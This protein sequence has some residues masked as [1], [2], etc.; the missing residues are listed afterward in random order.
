MLTVQ[1]TTLNRECLLDRPDVLAVVDFDAN[2]GERPT[3]ARHIVTPLA[4]DTPY[5]EVWTSPSGPVT[6]GTSG[7]IHYARTDSET[8]GSLILE[9][10]GEDIETLAHRA[11]AELLAWLGQQ[12][13]QRLW[14]VWNFFSD[15]NDGEGDDERYRRFSLGRHRALR[16]SALPEQALPPATAIGCEAAQVFLMFIAGAAP[17]EPVENPRQISAYRYPRQYGPAS[18]S[19]ARAAKVNNAAGGALIVS[20]PASIVGHETRHEGDWRR[21]LDETHRNLASLTQR[22]DVAAAP[23]AL[24]AYTRPG[25][26]AYE[27]IERIQGQ[28]GR[29]ITV[30]P[31]RGEICR[32][33]LL[34]EIEGLWPLAAPGATGEPES[35]P[36]DT[37]AIRT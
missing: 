3:D 26:P 23:A 6:T 37:T 34:L 24:R 18:P 22:A 17:C 30:I 1:T 33:D 5:R 13:H 7:A 21:Q 19:F 8:I 12:N 31:L 29:G 25:V 28:W 27:L 4:A 35:Q 2:P 14:R 15:I 20:G 32:R 36:A 9:D 10:Q 11:Y 16:E